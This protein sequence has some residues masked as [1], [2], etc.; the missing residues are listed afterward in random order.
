MT[1][2]KK[3]GDAGSWPLATNQGDVKSQLSAILD[4]LRQIIGGANIASGSSESTDPLTAPFRLYVDPYIGRDTFAAGSY[5]TTEAAAGSTTQQI[6]DQKLKRLENQRLLCG[7]SPQ[8]PF[9]TLNRA[10]IEAAIIT[11]KNWYISDPLAHVDCVCICLSP[12]LHIVYN[13]P[14][15]DGSAIAVSQWADGFE[16]TWQHLISFNPTEGGILLPRGASVVSLTGDLRHTILRPSWVPNGAVDESPTYASGVATYALRRQI[17]KTTGGGYA[18]GLTF[19]DQLGSTSSHHLL[20]GFGHATQAELNSFYGKVW[21]ACGSGGN[22]SQALLVARGTEYTIAAPI[23]GNPS[24]SWD[25]TNSA[26]FYIFQCSVRSDYGM[27]RL[28]AD[29]AKVEGFKSFVLANYTGVSLQKDIA[30]WQKY[31]A[32]NWVSVTD[33]AD[34]I[35]QVPDNRRQNPARRWIGIAAI[36]EAFIQKVSIFDIGEAAQSFVDTGGEIDSNNG[37]SSFGGVAGLARGYR[38]AALPQDKSWQVSA[39]RVPL[40][41]QYKTGN[42]QRLYLGTV[43][44]ISSSRITL[45]DALAAYGSS[46]TIPDLLG[47]KGYSLPSGSYIWIENAQGTDWR[48]PAT[49]SAW[50]SSSPTF[51]NISAA[52]TDPNGGDIGS[53]GDGVSLAIGARV[54]VRRLV[55]TRT[56]SERRLSVRLSN[57]TRV[58]LP[59]AHHILQTDI[60]SGSISRN[61]SSSELVLVSTSGTGSTPG[62]GVLKT[63]EVTL[64]RGGTAVTYAN[65]TFYRAGT[66]VLS[67]NK[68]WINSQDLTTAQATPDPALWQETYVHMESSY[69]PED[70]IRNESPI[71][72]FDTDTDG[73][74]TTTTCGINWSTAWTASATVYGQYRT[75]VDYLG[76]HLLLTALGYSSNDAHSALIPRSEESRDRNPALTSSPTTT[77]ALSSIIPAGGAATGAANWAVEFRRPSTIWMGSHRWFTSGSGNYSMSV[78]KA[79]QDMGAQN[80]FTYMFTGQGGGRVIPQ[81][82]QEDG[83]LVSPRGLEDV[84][85]GQTQTVENIGAGDINTSTSN[86]RD[87]LTITQLL[88][89]DGTAEFNGPVLFSDPVAQQAQTTR[90]GPVYLAKLADLQKTGAAASVATTDGQINGSPDVVTVAGLNAWRRAQQLVSTSTGSVVIYVKATADDRNL[91]SMLASP[92]TT[93]ARAVPSFARASEYLNQILIGSEQIGIVRVAPGLYDPTSVWNCRVIFEAWNAAFSAMPFPGNSTGNTSTPNN[94]YDGTGYDDFAAIPNL[95]AFRLGVRAANTAGTTGGNTNLNINCLGMTMRFN[96]SVQ[97]RG[98]FA[99]LGLAE[100]IKAIGNNLYP[101]TKFVFSYDVSDPPSGSAGWGTTAQIN[102]LT[103]STTNYGLDGSGNHRTPNVDALISSIRTSSGFT[104]DFDTWTTAPVIDIQSRDTDSALITDIIFGPGLPSHKEQLG[105][106]RDGYVQVATGAP[107]TVSNIYFRGNTVLTSAG[108]GCTNNL[109][110]ANVLHYGSSVVTT[111]W[112]WRQFFHTF[113]TAA[114]VSNE[115]NIQ[116]LGGLTSMR[117]GTGGLDYTFYKDISPGGGKFLPNHVHLIMSSSTSSTL[118]YPTAGDVT[119]GPF[120]DQL[121]HAKSAI[122]VTR[123]WA[124]FG[125]QGTSGTIH[126]GFVGRFG[127]NGFNSAKTRGI[128]LGVPNSTLTP[129]GFTQIKIGS[130]VATV[131]GPTTAVGIF[132]R[133]GGN[134]SA[135]GIT[136]TTLPFSGSPSYGEASPS[137]S[138]PVITTADNGSATLDLNMGGRSW[139]AGISSQYGTIISVRVTC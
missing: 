32:G 97:F 72:V 48:A 54:Y 112:T 132:R 125:A 128:L 129:E 88:T 116:Q 18:Y 105:G 71:L 82:S 69:A 41:P 42:I 138:N 15:T 77:L 108:I 59:A 98:G 53:G 31:S 30:N 89:V 135:S 107:L 14:S 38:A 119:N 130:D 127:A 13:N 7:Y 92:P 139:E 110:K 1:V 117:L 121:F 81:G 56:P 11:S 113:I 70:N 62:A 51:L 5:N 83:L 102:A 73:S 55:D 126:S 23:S 133:A 29:G 76:V 75:G 74:E 8:R 58:R 96:R 6:V 61:L 99:L 60:T 122:T 84:A 90:L 9:K 91:S 34:L 50:S 67:G 63:A 106:V 87:V 109:P 43:S 136:T 66:V 93:P 123:A 10:I 40:S 39:I 24:A 44:A 134:A 52:A 37:N 4:G 95:V 124:S 118:Y 79:A 36:N 25:S 131:S 35:N 120:F 114:S 12:A 115:L 22:L 94:Y 46:L 33:Y 49:A 103:Y 17:L 47:Q 27:G 57:T 65:S 45:T 101:A 111:P 68:H 78:P 26:S 64:R 19:R 3:A 20:S 28:W 100:T 85:T 86:E 137:G 80:R 2:V 104:G 16:P 21:T